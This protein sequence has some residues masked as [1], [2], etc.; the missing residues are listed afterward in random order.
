MFVRILL[1]TLFAAALG[2]VPAGALSVLV[3]VDTTPIAG[4]SGYVALDFIDGDGLVSNTVT[5]DAFGTD[6]AFGPTSHTGD[7]SGDLGSGPLVLGDSSFFN[8]GLVP[9]LF[10]TI[11]GFTLDVT[12]NGPYTPAPDAFSLFILD[13]GLNPLL[14]ND[15][16]GAS[17]LLF[18]E[19]DGDPVKTT[20][21]LSAGAAV[22]LVPEPS[23]GV[24]V[25]GAL[26]WA[27][28]RRTGER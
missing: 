21:Y 27:G 23:L 1:A 19:I 4:V 3:L 11:F 5:I 6:G 26:G 2:A 16:T 8:E 25:L 15:P 17:S 18:V 24:F 9:F 13:L 7:A 14:T 22:T 28:A 20:V 12:A 10:G